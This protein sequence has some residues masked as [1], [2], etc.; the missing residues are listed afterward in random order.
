MHSWK[1]WVDRI[2]AKAV[3][4]CL[5]RKAIRIP[6]TPKCYQTT[7][8]ESKPPHQHSKWSQSDCSP[9]GFPSAAGRGQVVSGADDVREAIFMAL[10]SSPKLRW[11]GWT[12]AGWRLD[13]RWMDGLCSN[14]SHLL[15]HRVASEHCA[16]DC[17][18]SSTYLS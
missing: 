6:A 15:M 13:C 18:W 5:S 14:K 12:V 7:P 1:L 11:N 4:C 2:V 9:S 3:P 8:T 16:L 17:S 10:E